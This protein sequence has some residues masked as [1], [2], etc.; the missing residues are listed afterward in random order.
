MIDTVVIQ[1]PLSMNE[2]EHVKLALNEK[3]SVDVSTGVIDYTMF[4]GKVSTGRTL[5]NVVIRT[6]AWQILPGRR[7]PAMRPLDNPLMIVEVSYHKAMMGHNVFGGPRDVYASTCWYLAELYERLDICLGNPEEW[8]YTR[9]DI[10]ETYDLGSEENVIAW[11]NARKLAHYPRR[12]VAFYG[13]SGLIASGSTTT[14]RAY[15]KG[16]EHAKMGGHKELSRNQHD[17]AGAVMAA[18]RRYLRCELQINKEK[19]AKLSQPSATCATIRRGELN[20]L[21]DSEWA[22][23][24]HEATYTSR[25]IRASSDVWEVLALRYPKRAIGLFG[26]WM[27]LATHNEQWYREQIGTRTWYEQKAI[28]KELAISWAATDVANMECPIAEFV[29]QFSDHRRVRDTSRAVVLAE[30]AYA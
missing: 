12:S 22:K 5:S 1:R 14:L 2:Y 21:Y 19:L 28:F 6:Q 13:D 8:T 24:I 26:A 10:A 23:M 15:A 18:A 3:R 30:S 16:A 20:D 27:I 11:V 9:L 29:P 17:T 4:A 7:V 25:V